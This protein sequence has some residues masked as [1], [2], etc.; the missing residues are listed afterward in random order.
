MGYTYSQIMK[1]FLLLAM[2]LPLA[3]STSRIAE[4]Q[5]HTGTYPGS[6][7]EFNG[8]LSFTLCLGN[9]CCGIN[10]ADNWLI[11]WQWDHL[12]EFHSEDLQECEGLKLN[13]QKKKDSL[14]MAKSQCSTLEET[15]GSGCTS[16][17]SQIPESTGNALF[18]SSLM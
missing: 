7:I 11:N 5:V 13:T 14:I 9:K 18:Q 2:I 15:A 12:D 8:H 10:N 17:F 16:E 4:M 6:G 1:V 3:L